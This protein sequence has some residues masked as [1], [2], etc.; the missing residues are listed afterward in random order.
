VDTFAPEPG[1]AAYYARAWRTY[2]ALYPAL[3]PIYPALASL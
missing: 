2:Q 1:A 3:R